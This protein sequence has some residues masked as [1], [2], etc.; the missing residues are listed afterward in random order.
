MS[1]K[2]AL[3]PASPFN[4]FA[5]IGETADEPQVDLIADE[6]ALYR[7]S[8]LKGWKVLREYIDQIEDDLEKM[9]STLIE[10]GASDEEIGRKTVVKEIVKN[11]T[12]KI[13]SRVDDARDAAGD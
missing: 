3:R 9:V 11:V 6:K 8:Q 2:Q 10:T 1:N 12:R 4:Q 7:L 5:T 13:K